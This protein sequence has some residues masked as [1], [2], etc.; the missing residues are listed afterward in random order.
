MRGRCFFG[1][2][3]HEQTALVGIGGHGTANIMANISS[4]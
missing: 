3:V 2:Y 1:T 4:D